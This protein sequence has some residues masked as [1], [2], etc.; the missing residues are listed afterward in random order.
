MQQRLKKSLMYAL[1]FAFGFFS[2][3]VLWGE[4][5]VL[6]TT[7]Q[8]RQIAGTLYTLSNE[9]QGKRSPGL[10]LFSLKSTRVNMSV[11]VGSVQVQVTQV[12]LNQSAKSLKAVYL[13]P[14]PQGAAVTKEVF[15]VA[16]RV[17]LSK[18]GT[19]QI[20]HADGENGVYTSSAIRCRPH[21]TVVVT[22]TYTQPLAY[23]QGMYSVLFPVTPENQ[24]DEPTG[25]HLDPEHRFILSVDIAGLSLT[26]IKSNT[27]EILIEERGAL[28]YGVFLAD[29]TTLPAG[30][31]V[32]D[33]LQEENSNQQPFVF[34]GLPEKKQNSRAGR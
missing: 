32:L 28:H 2:V 12:F 4:T 21:H 20:R 13:F 10:P 14:L 15:T 24:D 23:H 1:S 33:M 9:G 7:N 3:V 27:H 31:F 30:N 16:Q 25:P 6:H 5:I 11:V 8:N 18:T 29:E 26:R 19:S 22:L 34:S 17:V